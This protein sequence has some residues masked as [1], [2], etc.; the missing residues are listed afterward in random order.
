MFFNLLAAFAEFEVDIIRLRTIEGTARA[1]QRGKL[2]GKQSK[3]KSPAAGASAP[4][5]LGGQEEPDRAVRG[6]AG[7]DLPGAEEGTRGGGVTA[8]PTEPAHGRTPDRM[9]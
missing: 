2:K 9:K 5:R 8:Q 4:A 7:D 3:L 1:R 6:V